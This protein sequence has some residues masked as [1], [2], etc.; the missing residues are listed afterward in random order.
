M[1]KMWVQTS[2]A[3]NMTVVD[4]RMQKP[5][6]DRRILFHDGELMKVSATEIETPW[7]D[8]P[9]GGQTPYALKMPEEKSWEEAR[10]LPTPGNPRPQGDTGTPSEP[11]LQRRLIITTDDY[12]VMADY[13][14]GSEEHDFDNLFN[15]K[16]LVDLAGKTEF[17]KHT[18]QCDPDPYSSAQFI[19]DCNW[20]DTE[21]TVKAGFVLDWSKGEMGGRHSCSEPGVMNVDY[22]SLWPKKAE[23]MVGNY[24][25]SHNVARQ[26][27]YKVLGDGQVLAEGQFAPWILGSAEIDVDVR[28]FQTLE[29]ETRVEKARDLKTIFLGSPQLLDA[30]GSEI[31]FDV[32][33]ENVAPAAGNNLDY[34]GG[35]V[36]IFGE[37]YAVSIAAEPA[38]RKQAGKLTIDLTG[39]KAARFT[40]VLGGD[41]PVGDDIQRKIVATRS[42]GTE[43]RF[44]SAV[45]LH[46]DSP[47]IQSI[48]ALS[49]EEVV[50][51]RRDG[52]VDRFMISGLDDSEVAVEMTVE[53]AGQVT[54]SE[55]TK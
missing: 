39:K 5:G 1:F 25:E 14:K 49:A 43:A 50:V 30:T 19:T 52:Q 20:Y 17:V 4:H 34:A 7:I 16:G 22:Y 12:V 36:T 24:P 40:A 35:A 44:L 51:L 6:T 31:A 32:E 3:H 13:L 21:G 54:A 26:L 38:D 37:P 47:V 8:P 42:T 11:V 18:A 10:W 23:L 53:K 45:E 2:D 29:I 9:Y 48:E 28:G 27:F 46:E 41:Y 33:T 55:K 15:C